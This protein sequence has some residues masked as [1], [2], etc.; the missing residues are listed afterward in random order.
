MPGPRDSEVDLR[1]ALVDGQFELVYQPIY[2]LDELA[3]VG[4]EALLRWNHP[5]R[6]QIQ[7]DEF[8]PALEATGQIVDVGRWVF[9]EACR[10]MAAWRGSG[11]AL[12]VSVNVSAGQLARDG[13]VEDV[14]AAL[15]LSGLAPAAL[16][17]EVAE[18]TLL[19]NAEA[20]ARRLHALKDLGVQVAIDD[21][22]TGYSSLA[23]LRQFP[24]DCLK[25]DRTFIEAVTRSPQADALIHTLVQLGRDLGLKTLA[26]GVETT[27]Q[28]TQ[29]R[30]ENVNSVQGFLF[31]RPLTVAAIDEGILHVE[32][33]PQ[34]DPA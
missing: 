12:T 20:S 8:L 30:A 33:D 9:T 7:P 34:A 31:A 13:I 32:P 19:H 25:I 22:G 17:V 6:G 11:S 26:E 14:R 18:T 21:F 27:E 23:Y 24:A 10:Q 2:D 28:M 16:T 29:L 5:A 15:E 4:F 3:L 1:S